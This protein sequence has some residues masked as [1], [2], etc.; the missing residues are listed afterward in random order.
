MLNS[1]AEELVTLI[2]RRAPEYLDLFTA[3]TEQEFETAFNAILER[4]VRGLERNCKHF[5][6]LDEEGLSGVLAQGLSVP[7]F[8]VQQEALSK[9]H[10][11]LTI[12]MNHCAPART[13]L[14]EAKI[15]RG[16]QNHV[17]GLGQLLS[18]YTTGRESR[19]LLI[20]YFRQ[21]GIAGLVQKI[22]E[23]MDGEM[24]LDQQGKTA[25]HALK[26]SFISVHA[27]SCGENLEVG[28]IGCNLHVE[29]QTAAEAAPA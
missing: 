11:D 28:H 14:A 2:Q 4:A 20:V 3:R 17:A 21:K 15:Y 26:W 9:G 13:K 24:P 7:G 22:R 12:E 19:G 25:D 23:M 10:V 1:N 27:H 6:S 29:P 5:A 16:P 8:S 18:R